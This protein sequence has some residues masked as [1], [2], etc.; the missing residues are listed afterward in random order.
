MKKCLLLWFAIISFSL[1]NSQDKDKIL[2]L[3]YF[4]SIPGV[5][6]GCNGIYTN[7]SISLKKKKYV[8]ISNIQDLGIIRVNGNA[9]SLK[10]IS[11]TE[12]K[13]NIFKTIYKGEGYTAIL[14][15]KD[16]KQIGD[17]GSYEM[18][19]LEIIYGHSSVKFKIHGEAGC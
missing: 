7:D 11:T 19:T 8:F 6:D 12:T 10:L 13:K 3:D 15:V 2:K 9:I 18:G 1:C 16:V 4:T 14:I 5:I 17:E